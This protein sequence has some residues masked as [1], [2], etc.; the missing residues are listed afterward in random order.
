[1]YTAGSNWTSSFAAT[2]SSPAWDERPREKMTTL[3]SGQKNFL[4]LGR[5]QL[6][7]AIT[8]CPGGGD[9]PPYSFLH[10]LGLPC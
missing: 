7:Q 8:R 3:S 5:A 6:H 1:M 2:S 9:S 4:I 10:K